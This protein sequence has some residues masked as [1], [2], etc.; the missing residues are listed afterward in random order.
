MEICPLL[1]LRLERDFLAA[2]NTS[3]NKLKRRII[4]NVALLLAAIFA[5]M[6]MSARENRMRHI[7]QISAYIDVLSNRTAMH[8]SDVLQDR[9]VAIDS[10]AYLYGDTLTSRDP[11]LPRLA[12]LESCS[13]FDRIRFIDEQGMSYASNGE[14]V[15]CSDREYFERGILGESGI[16][17]SLK[18]RF[19][20]QRL[21]GF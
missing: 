4:I 1:F 12:E 6:I 16:Y 2:M 5:I 3:D 14:T 10:I 19:D 8:V 9:E 11:D 13:N 21:I 18:S 7:Q 17:T 20:G 15:D